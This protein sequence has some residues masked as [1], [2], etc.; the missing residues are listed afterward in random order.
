MVVSG[1]IARRSG[2]VGGGV[3]RWSF[4]VDAAAERHHFEGVAHDR[5]WLGAFNGLAMENMPG[6]LDTSLQRFNRS[7]AS[8]HQKKGRRAPS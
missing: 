3:L 5:P 8:P 2:R 1:I 4:V 6:P 7:G